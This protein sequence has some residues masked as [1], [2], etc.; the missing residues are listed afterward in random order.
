MC[1]NTLEQAQLLHSLG[2]MMWELG[3]DD[4][5]MA[6]FNE[7]TSF[8]EYTMLHTYH[9]ICNR[10]PGTLD[11]S[12][13][14]QAC[15]RLTSKIEF[16]R[17]NYDACLQC[18]Y[19]SLVDDEDYLYNVRF[20]DMGMGPEAAKDNFGSTLADRVSSSAVERWIF[21]MPLHT[22]QLPSH[23]YGGE[24]DCI[25]H[26]TADWIYELFHIYSEICAC[27]FQ[28]GRKDDVNRLQ[29]LQLRRTTWR[30]LQPRPTSDK[31]VADANADGANPDAVANNDVKDKFMCVKESDI[32]PLL[33]LHHSIAEQCNTIGHVCYD[34]QKACHHYQQLLVYKTEGKYDEQ[35]C[36]WYRRKAW[37]A[38]AMLAKSKHK[39]G[40]GIAWESEGELTEC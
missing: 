19:S 15:W 20:R 24:G 8:Y 36:D 6:R 22:R 30:H 28:Q 5:A 11:G 25:G 12:G 33:Q 3:D 31:T 32:G 21:L 23:R 16:K 26:Y 18:L 4:S 34:V 9:R 1:R 38:L 10:R 2:H 14:R 39:G 37:E 35:R 29:D 13:L 7:V 27:W 40:A 17:Q